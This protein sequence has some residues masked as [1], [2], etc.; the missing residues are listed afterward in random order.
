MAF[1]M[2]LKTAYPQRPPGVPQKEIWIRKDLKIKLATDRHRLTQTF[3]HFSFADVGNIK[4][5]VI[6]RKFLYYQDRLPFPG[7]TQP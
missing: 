1:S 7:F 3:I 5:A 4:G 6:K 2:D